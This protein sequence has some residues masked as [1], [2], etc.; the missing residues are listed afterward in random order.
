MIRRPPRSTRTDTLFPYTTLFRSRPVRDSRHS[1]GKIHLMLVIHWRSRC[2]AGPQPQT[3]LSLSS[4]TYLHSY[5]LHN[6]DRWP[7][8]LNRQ[9]TKLSLGPLLRS[10]PVRLSIAGALSRSRRA[11]SETRPVGK[12][13][14]R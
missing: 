5:R 9:A 3:R 14:V 11:Q 13:G 7:R 4:K 2:R 8:S 1:V 6:G 10:T 12:E